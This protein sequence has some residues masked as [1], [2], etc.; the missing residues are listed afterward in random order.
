MRDPVV[1]FAAIAKL[2]Q[3]QRVAIVF[4]SQV[5]G[6]RTRSSFVRSEAAYGPC[7]LYPIAVAFKIASRQRC[8]FSFAHQAF[9]CDAMTGKFCEL[10]FSAPLG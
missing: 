3:R 2:A 8:K 6:A 4:Y 7:A 5:Q 10:R 1:D 9:D